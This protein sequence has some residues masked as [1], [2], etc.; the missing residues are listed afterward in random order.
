[1]TAKFD[2]TKKTLLQSTMDTLDCGEHYAKEVID[3]IID[4]GEEF[5]EK[6]V[7][8]CDEYLQYDARA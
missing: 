8:E 6:S 2:L 1:M 4:A 5:T 3:A 7:K